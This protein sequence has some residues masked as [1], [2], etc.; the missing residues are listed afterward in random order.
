MSGAPERW[1]LHCDLSSGQRV[2]FN[3]PTQSAALTCEM[4]IVDTA[5]S[6]LLVLY[7]RHDAPNDE[8]AGQRLGSVRTSAVVATHVIRTS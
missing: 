5:G 4:D 2:T 1:S 6:G 3:F 8:D 7:E